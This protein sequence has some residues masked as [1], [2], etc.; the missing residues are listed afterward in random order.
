MKGAVSLVINV[1]RG[2]KKSSRL[3]ALVTFVRLVN[4]EKKSKKTTAFSTLKIINDFF[5][6][7]PFL[8]A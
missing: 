6:R 3:G 4:H 5:L 7:L 1:V 8:I 2:L